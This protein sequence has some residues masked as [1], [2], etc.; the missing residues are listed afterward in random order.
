MPSGGWSRWGWWRSVEAG[1]PEELEKALPADSSE[2]DLVAYAACARRRES[3]GSSAC[4]RCRAVSTGLSAE[5]GSGRVSLISSSPNSV[6]EI[7]SIRVRRTRDPMT[8]HALLALFLLTI[9]SPSQI[10]DAIPAGSDR[11]AACHRTGRATGPGGDCPRRLF[12]ANGG[13][14]VTGSGQSAPSA[15]C[16]CPGESLHLFQIRSFTAF[17]RSNE[18]LYGDFTLVPLGPDRPGVMREMCFVAAANLT[19]RDTQSGARRILEGK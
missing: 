19:V 10:I 3:R 2:A 13:G 11:T 6:N 17:D 5:G 18:E 7:C 1:N 12:A 8:A 16:G 9:D 14:S 4:Q 15:S